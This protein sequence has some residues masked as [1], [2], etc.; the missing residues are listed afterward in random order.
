M[1]LTPAAEGNRTSAA[2]VWQHGERRGVWHPNGF[3]RPGIARRPDV[4]VAGIAVTAA[5]GIGVR[6]R[7]PI[8]DAPIRLAQN[9]AKDSAT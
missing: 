3:L 5:V 4:L 1:H 7:F 6:E 8:L 9:S 2:P